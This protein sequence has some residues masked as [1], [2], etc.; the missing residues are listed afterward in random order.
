MALSLTGLMNYQAQDTTGTVLFT[1]G[2]FTPADNSILVAHVGV[3][4]GVGG[5]D[6]QSGMS[7]SGGGLTWTRQAGPTGGTVAGYTAA[8]EIWTAPVTTGASMSITYQHAGNVGSDRAWGMIQVHEITSD[9]TS[10]EIG[11]PNVI[12]GAHDQ[13]D[14][15][16]TITLPSSPSSSSI[17]SAARYYNSNA[18]DGAATPGTGWTEVY[19]QTA[20]TNG[21]GSFQSQYRGSS[22]DA[23]VT[24]NN[25]M[26]P[27]ETAWKSSTMAIEVREAAAGASVVPV[28]ERQYLGELINEGKLSAKD[29][30]LAATILATSQVKNRREMLAVLGAYSLLVIGK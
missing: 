26:V 25:L 13:G 18:N 24:W 2:S 17:V 21:Y 16:A 6:V 28:L 23:D 3:V 7:L 29:A 1:T 8:Q 27:A 9:S 22:T 14:A 30:G 15:A 5:A 10:P 19:D 12:V 20:S 11:T 4:N